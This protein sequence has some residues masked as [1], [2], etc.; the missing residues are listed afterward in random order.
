MSLCL[1]SHHP[2]PP[3]FPYFTSWEAKKG[4]HQ[5]PKASVDG[6]RHPYETTTFLFGCGEEDKTSNHH[7]KKSGC[8]M[9]RF[10]SPSKF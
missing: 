6:F 3:D 2:Q 1:E 7:I 4:H 8:V 5:Q 10:P 9:R